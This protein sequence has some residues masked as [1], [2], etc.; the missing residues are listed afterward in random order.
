MMVQRDYDN[1]YL[2]LVTSLLSLQQMYKNKYNVTSSENYDLSYHFSTNFSTP[3]FSVN[4][5]KFL[6][7]GINNLAQISCYPKGINCNQINNLQDKIDQY[8]A[9]KD[10]ATQQCKIAVEFII[11]NISY[12]YQDF[13]IIFTVDYQ[14]NKTNVK[15]I[16]GVFNTE[17]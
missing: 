4:N 11:Q 16:E 10:G 2:K 7:Q 14:E 12:I 1:R 3:I 9:K 15:L 6:N 8:C 13:G 17:F 5:L